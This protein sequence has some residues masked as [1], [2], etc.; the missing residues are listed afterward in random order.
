MLERCNLRA[1]IAGM[2]R[3]SIGLAGLAALVVML[4]PAVTEAKTLYV[5]G[6]SGNDSVSYANNSSSAPWRTIGRAAWGST[7]RSSPNGAE[8]AKAG[9]VV[10]IAAGTYS[11]VGNLTGGGFGRLDVAYNPANEGRPGSPIRFEAVGTVVL[12]FTSGA[13]PMIGAYQRDYIE[14]SGFTISESTAPTRSD[15]GPVTFFEVTGGAIESSILTGN[16]NWTAR[17]GDNYSGVRVEDASGIRIA[18]NTIR[19]YGGQTNDENH[20]GIETYRSFPLLIE[21]NFISNCGAGIYMKAVNPETL[22][23][24]TVIIRYNVISG[25]PTGVRFLRMP[26]TAARPMLVYQN[27]FTNWGEAGVWWNV[28]DNGPTDPTWIRV[29]NNTFVGSGGAGV[30]TYNHTAFK[31]GTNSLFRNNIV[32]GGTVS[33]RM[34]TTDLTANTRKDR[35]DFDRNVYHAPSDAFGNLAGED[36]T[37]Q[38]WQNLGQDASGTVADPLFVNRGGG[39][40]RLQANSPARSLGRAVHSVGGSDGTVI[41]AGAYITGS[42]VIGPS[43]G[44]V[45]DPPR[46]PP[47]T[48]PSAPGNLRILR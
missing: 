47:L 35:F 4:A 38:F 17:V 36:R 41:P 33:V 28:F 22:V 8:A 29:F 31:P 20:N 45:V 24:D 27:I 48:P 6:S 5:N 11:T 12:T 39:D 43:S 9:D 3:Q 10:R 23:V 32:S 34:D 13:G 19:N 42:E 37:F 15:T 46:D 7:N 30:G 2:A 14:W 21:N 40:Y 25:N 26:M 44:Y 1:T 16:P 18:N